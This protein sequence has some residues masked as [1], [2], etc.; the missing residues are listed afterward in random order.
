MS[1][2][3]PTGPVSGDW[4]SVEPFAEDLFKAL[5]IRRT[6]ERLLELFKEGRIFGTVHTCIGQ[7]LT[8]IAVAK[9]LRKEDF[10]VSNHRCHG[11]YLARTDDVEGLIAEV[12]GKET[13]VCAG[14]GGSQHLCS[15]DFFSN[16][17][18]GGMMPVAAGMA[19]ARRLRAD[20]SIGVIF[21]GDGTLGEGVFYEALNLISKWQL[22]LLIVLE[23]NGYSQSTAQSET[24]AGDIGARARAFG[25]STYKSDTWNI[26]DLLE[27][28]RQTVERV[29]DTGRPAFLEIETY[30]LAPHSKGDDTRDP[31]EIA[32]YASKD[33]LNRLLLMAEDSPELCSALSVIERR[34]ESAIAKAEIANVQALGSAVSSPA[35]PT[36]WQRLTF[37]EERVV[38][39]VRRALSDALASDPRVVILGEDVRSP[40]G[41]AFKITQGLSDQAPT[42]VLNTPVSEA[43]IV[44]IGSGLALQGFRPAVEIMFGD[45][46]LLAADQIVN[47]AAKFRWMYNNRVTVPLIIRTP[48]GGRRG[49]GPTHSQSL[50]KHFLGVPGTQ[51][52]ALHHRYPPA[53]VY[54]TLLSTVN[55]PTIV[56][57]NKI[58]YG[59]VVSDRIPAGFSLEATDDDFPTVRLAPQEHAEVTLVAYG[60]MAIEAEAAAQALFDKHEIL[61]DLLIPLRLYPLDTEPLRDSVERT[62]RIVV[63][64]EGYGFA[65]LGSELIS[66]LNESSEKAFR[67]RRV[68]AAPNPIPTSR[69]LEEITLPDR[70]M[71]VSAVREIM[72]G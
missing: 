51:V 17:I 44:G 21:V 39:A 15:G 52:L 36:K 61:V 60:A 72:N 46:M 2:P 12:M 22:P 16:G 18:L 11:H 63:V 43:A 45:F 3:D 42:R 70:E 58:L 53:Q 29:R 26:R 7:E 8:G 55:C 9:A 33:L 68:A 25:L 31:Q 40:Y 24:L 56:I 34:V 14:R 32:A 37:A 27:T 65:G 4:P 23:N 64:E 47:H 20:G 28:A 38:L 41:G 67:A 6:E 5:L 35:V 69:P 49:Y 66:Q 13:G 30:R 57:E 19:L 10:V 1:V 62:G 48:M 59:V 54:Q 50:E 71:I